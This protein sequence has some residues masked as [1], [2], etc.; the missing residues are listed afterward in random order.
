MTNIVQPIDAG[1][2]R[3]LR[4][5]RCAIG[6]ASDEWLLV[7]ENLKKWESKMTAGERRILITWW[8]A[9]GMDFV[10]QKVRRRWKM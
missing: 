4:S 7:N 1:T 8:V 10:T 5:L 9:K 6:R 2:G 3:S